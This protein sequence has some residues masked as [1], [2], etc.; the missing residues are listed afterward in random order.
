MKMYSLILRVVIYVLL[1]L[2]HI[3]LLSE[4]ST[5]SRPTLRYEIYTIGKIELSET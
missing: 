2:S 4:I 5:F 1:T 3:L